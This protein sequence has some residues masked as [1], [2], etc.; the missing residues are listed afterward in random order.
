MAC[1]GDRSLAVS[2]RYGDERIQQKKCSFCD[3]ESRAR[4]PP[5]RWQGADAEE[6]LTTTVN[7]IKV[8]RTQNYRQPRVAAMMAS[9]RILSHV[10]DANPL[11]LASSSLGQMTLQAL[12][13][14]VR[15]LRIAAGYIK[16]L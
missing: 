2:D 4:P 12:H 9:K 13:S 14:S 3:A 6:I 7:L 5:V 8:P 16:R 10:T 15:E 11:N 1:I